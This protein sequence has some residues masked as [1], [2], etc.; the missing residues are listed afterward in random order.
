MTDAHID[1]G[2]SF[3]DSLGD[4]GRRRAEPRT[5]ISLAGAGCALAIVG[6]LALAGDTGVD[7]DSGD[8]T[9]V[10]GVLLSAL[11]IVIGYFVLS[12]VRRGPVATAG[13]V[14]AA[15]GVPAFM[16]FVT[17]DENGLPPYNTEAILIVATAV[18]LGTYL[19]GPG[20]G[21]PFFLGSGLIALWFTVLELTENVFESP[22]DAFRSSFLGI[23]G[24]ESFEATGDLIDPTTGEIIDAGSDPIVTGGFDEISYD[25]PDPTTIGILSLVL[26]V[27]FLL[28]GRRL[29]R[30]GRHG[31]ATPFSFAALPCLAVGVLGVAPDLEASGTGLLLV[32]IGL[33]LAYNGA[34]VWRRAT[35]WLGGAA[36][37]VGLALFLGDNAG[38]SVTTAGMLFIAGGVGMVFIGHLIASA[39]IEPD[40]LTVTV[41]GPVEAAE[42]VLV[43]QPAAPTE[44]AEDADPHAPWKPPIPPPPA[45]PDDDPP[46]AK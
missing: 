9:R 25:P 36:M 40:E 6:V 44:D 8:F 12:A 42:R 37:A 23:E 26:G 38:E 31:A 1:A 17:F 3:L 16:F 35:S 34:T 13:A 18:W 27:V 19:F 21:R 5:S 29:D 33:A 30:S 32:G 4:R 46:P 10:P 2:D 11:V 41:G 28:V 39:T 22:F 45:A 14:A 20:R 7:E 24:S 43:A 15:L